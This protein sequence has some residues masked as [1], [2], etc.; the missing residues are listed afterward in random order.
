MV[1]RSAKLVSTA[2]DLLAQAGRELTHVTSTDE[3]MAWLRQ[4]ASGL[5]IVE[6]DFKTGW[7]SDIGELLKSIKAQPGVKLLALVRA[8]E[9]A[10]FRRVFTIY[11]LRN[12]LAVS[13]ADQ[14]DS[15][16]LGATISK[17]LNPDLFGAQRYLESSPV[18]W[19]AEVRKS[20]QRP[21]IVETTEL[22][23]SRM[24]FH[25]SVA[26]V[27]ATVVDELITNAL[28]NA[29]RDTAGNSRFVRTHRAAPVTL[30]SDEKVTVR[31]V[32][33]HRKLCI[34]VC[35]P[36]GSMTPERAIDCL[37]RCFGMGKDQVNFGGSGAGLGLY[38]IFNLVHH[39]V[40]NIAPS[41]LTE[42]IG[43]IHLTRSYKDYKQMSRSLNVFVEE[44]P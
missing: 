43:I 3:A 2:R 27:T 1:S 6:L 38:F 12:F 14:L 4:T 41:R 10:Q 31:L 44:H 16:E 25:A 7:S 42:A 15:V 33:D 34:S 21:A 19:V 40:I 11:R 39:L 35:D 9:P 37:A 26:E 8:S 24:G 22:F 23:A 28:Y 13:E 32:R 18:E 29:P 36:Y 5:A 17:L 20:D 30:A